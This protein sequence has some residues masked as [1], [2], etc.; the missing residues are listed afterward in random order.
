MD[1]GVMWW[2]NVDWIHLSQD[3]GQWWAVV[4][5]Q[6]HKKGEI[7]W[8]SERLL[9]SQEGLCSLELV[10]LQYCYHLLRL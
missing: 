5:L 8:S 6:L 3:R 1:L 7:S 10:I 2:E 4:N 9:A